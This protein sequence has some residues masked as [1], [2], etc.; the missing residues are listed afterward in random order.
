VTGDDDDDD[1]DVSQEPVP[2]IVSLKPLE[3]TCRSETSVQLYIL[4]HRELLLV[5]CDAFI[6]ILWPK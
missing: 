4:L 3:E 5:F 6:P 2:L 1:D